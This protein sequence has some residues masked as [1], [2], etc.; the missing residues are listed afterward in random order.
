MKKILNAVLC[1][2][3]TILIVGIASTTI[4][5]ILKFRDPTDVGSDSSSSADSSSGSEELPEGVYRIHYKLAGTE[6]DLFP[7]YEW[8]KESGGDYPETYDT[9]E[10]AS[11][12]ALAGSASYVDWEGW[13]GAYMVSYRH[14]PDDP[15]EMAAFWAWY[16]DPD[17]AEEF[18]GEIAAG[19]EGD[20][21]IY[22]K[23]ELD[24]EGFWTDFY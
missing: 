20:V 14:N 15:N 18:S 2:V 9:V 11:V 23:L 22:A 6:D 12:S 3:M 10:G 17:C 4:Q 1:V 24:N 13:E 5:N 8:M 21:T 19:T 7:A 16:L